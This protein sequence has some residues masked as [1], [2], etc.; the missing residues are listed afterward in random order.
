M[1]A[2]CFSGGVG[3]DSAARTHLSRCWNGGLCHDLSLVNWPWGRCFSFSCE[4]SVVLD[5]ESVPCLEH[6]P[7]AMTRETIA[8]CTVSETIQPQAEI[9]SDCGAGIL[10]CMRATTACM[11]THVDSNAVFDESARENL[12]QA[13]RKHSAR[14]YSSFEPSP[15]QEEICSITQASKE[16]QNWMHLPEELKPLL[17]QEDGLSN[18]DCISDGIVNDLGYTVNKNISYN[19][20]LPFPV[21]S[22]SINTLET[23]GGEKYVLDYNEYA[24]S[25]AVSL[26]LEDE[27]RCH[28]NDLSASLPIT[29]RETMVLCND[30]DSDCQVVPLS[31]SPNLYPDLG[32]VPRINCQ[33]SDKS[34]VPQRQYNSV[35]NTSCNNASFVTLM[36]QN[37]SP[38]SLPASWPRRRPHS[39]R[40]AVCYSDPE[41]RHKGTFIDTPSKQEIGLNDMSVKTHALS[42]FSSTTSFLRERNGSPIASSESYRDDNSTETKS[43]VDTNQ[44]DHKD[45]E[46]VQTRL[47]DEEF[48]VKRSESEEKQCMESSEDLKMSTSADCSMNSDTKAIVLQSV[49]QDSQTE[50]DLTHNFENKETVYNDNL[51]SPSSDKEN[52]PALLSVRP[53]IHSLSKDHSSP[54]KKK[55]SPKK[56]FRSPKKQKLQDNSK[57]QKSLQQDDND[58]KCKKDD[59]HKF[60]S[61]DD[62]FWAVD[63]FLPIPSRSLSQSLPRVLQDSEISP[64]RNAKVN[65][66]SKLVKPYLNKYDANQPGSQVEIE[67]R[68]L[69][70]TFSSD[71][72]YETE[73]AASD[74]RS[75]SELGFV[76]EKKMSKKDLNLQGLGPQ[77]QPLP[78]THSK[79]SCY[80]LLSDLSTPV[81]TVSEPITP[82]TIA[83]DTAEYFSV[84]SQLTNPVHSSVDNM[85]SKYTGEDTP[86]YLSITSDMP[87]IP[88]LP[89]DSPLA[90][91]EMQQLF[92]DDAPYTQSMECSTETVESLDQPTVISEDSPESGEPSTLAETPATLTKSMV[93]EGIGDCEETP[94]LHEQ[95]SGEHSPSGISTS[96]GS[97]SNSVGNSPS[98]ELVEIKYVQLS[99]SIVLAIVLHA[100]Q[101]ISQF[102]LEIFLASDQEPNWD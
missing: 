15:P 51:M 28:K 58:S 19:K 5:D 4:G 54:K 55:T 81:D 87:G 91:F 68:A 71:T 85:V 97:S 29:P 9:V 73:S 74:Y 59:T 100:M 47:R 98:Q 45:V 23:F 27:I 30:L 94:S 11:V 57:N 75:K 56:K 79:H 13:I 69:N 16:V 90:D 61:L 50:S 43:V 92:S 102:M 72:G 34:I 20:V 40:V 26:G 44:V 53:K 60:G 14:G 82:H 3:K 38:A 89:E 37:R 1:S 99:L 66:V 67:G 41:C 10:P 96:S 24:K 83:D 62:D 2:G 78:L 84:C 52:D 80:S 32:S 63:D 48:T 49:P 18:E 88:R 17:E 77:D 101:S 39:L 76:D 64:L 8:G 36:G 22:K 12:C 42:P 35:V 86:D 95:L 46:E 7:E 31:F 25:H 65:R 6:S 33:V 93:E 21:I 70:S